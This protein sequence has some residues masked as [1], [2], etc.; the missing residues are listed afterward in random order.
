MTDKARKRLVLIDGKS[1]FYRGYYAMPNLATKEGVP[2]GGVYGFATLS[3]EIIKRL[4]PDY[5]AVAWDKSK[6]NIRKRVE[7]YPEYKAGRKPAP[8]DFY[9]QIPILHELL[10]SLGWP[11]YEIDDYEADDIMAGLAKKAEKEG[12]ETILITS[13]LDA[14]QCISDL[15]KVY[16]LKKGL[17]NIEEFHP[18]SFRAKYGLNPEQ[19]LDLK[20]LQGDSSDNIPGVPGVGVKT[21]ID[22]LQ[23]YDSLNGVYENIDLISGSVHDKLVKGRDLALISKE[24]ATLYTDAPIE[25]DLEAM[26]VHNF[27]GK[28]L[29]KNLEKLEFR[30][31]IRNLK[32]LPISSNVD[33]IEN[34]IAPGGK[35]ALPKLVNPHKFTLAKS[36]FVHGIAKDSLGKEVVAIIIAN[37]EEVTFFESFKDVS[38]LKEI[39][40]DVHLIGYDLKSSLKMLYYLGIE[41]FNVG[42]DIQIGE[43]L[44]N[45][46]SR[47]TSLDKLAQEYLD[48]NLVDL[49][50]LPPEDLGLHVAEIMASIKDIYIKQIGKFS[51]NKPLEKLAGTI[52]W[53][54]IPIIAKM[55]LEGIKI[56]VNLLNK[57]SRQLEDSISDLEQ[58]IYGYAEKEFNIASPQQLADVLFDDLKLPT[59]GI[60]KGKT[61][62]STAANE[63]DKLRD[64]HPIIDYIS[65]FREYS[66]LKN[67]YVDT[68]PKMVDQDSKLHTTF[69]LT[70]AQ[71]G[72]LSSV[73]PNLQNIPIRTEIG[74]S[75]RSAFIAKEGYSFVS[76][77]YSQFELR[78][79][80]YLAND[81]DMIEVFNNGEDIHIRT[82]AEVYGVA[83]DDVT[84]EMRS[85]AKTINFGVLYGMSPHGLSVAT[86]MTMADAK[87]FINRYFAARQPLVEYIASIKKQA[88]ELGYVETLYGRRRPTPDVNSSNFVVREAAYRQ[89]VNMPI[90]GTEADLMKLAMIKLDKELRS[91]FKSKPEQLLQIHD[92]ILVECL[93]SDVERVGQIM[94]Q[95][96]ETIDPNI[97]IKLAVDVK[98]GSNWGNL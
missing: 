79:A 77:D 76:A 80:A 55:E 69:N 20:S 31:I 29:L 43:F 72:R 39:L 88:K 33:L 47:S 46:L 16:A 54:V 8:A 52:E 18:E 4:E 25:L 94:K 37:E 12:I 62:Y 19:F 7:I 35:L 38:R 71:T 49:G 15:T 32:D 27:D 11:L 3:L 91:N 17:R 84:K 86:G 2:T 61:G 67:T 82:A 87:N 98:S 34:D 90:Q 51:E 40:K 95:T 56:D 45:S 21:A 58:T 66:K 81:E 53:P 59:Q 5:V 89:A 97:N 85:A 44:L 23:K 60:K 73:D 63:L 70:V 75:I 9:V 92:S 83:F 48:Y 57:I 28:R 65:K 14:L 30:A 42:H 1:V 96:M 10:A 64:F 68:L 6:T 50:Q 78:L 36:L 13:D 26:D 24:L 22:L 93:N 74:K 41:N